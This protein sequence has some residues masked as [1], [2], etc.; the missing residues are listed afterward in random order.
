[1]KVFVGSDGS[2]N[3]T[4][5]TPSVGSAITPNSGGNSGGSFRNPG[6]VGGAPQALQSATS[7]QGA[8][9]PKTPPSGSGGGG[10]TGSGGGG[11]TAPP[12]DY[13]S[14]L[15]LYGLPSDVQAEVDKIFA[16]TGDPNEAA[17]LALAYVRGTDWYK[18]TYPGIQQ[19]ISN[20]TV[21][22]EASYRAYVNNI[23]QLYQQYYGRNPTSDEISGYLIAGYNPS[24]VGNLL[25]GQAWTKVNSPEVKYLTG[26][27]TPNGGQMSQS[28]LNA[29]GKEQAG[30]DTTA[31]QLAQKVYKK[32]QQI[33]ARIQQGSLATPSLSLGATG[34]SSPSLAGG[35]VA[36]DVSA[37]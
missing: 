25:Q 1:M 4:P 27:F 35:K 5:S 9:E 34:L 13:S 12:G 16:T 7:Q 10:D 20:G 23:D 32:A 3:S 15:G 6:G 17:T 14:L 18:T 36:P 31:G 30:I 33:Q 26:A 24:Y 19:G 22:N 8:Q 37:T 29:L 28:D 11:S 21:S 2:V